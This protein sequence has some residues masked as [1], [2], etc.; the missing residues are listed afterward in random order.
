[1][2]EICSECQNK[3]DL[4]CFCSNVN[5]CRTCL[6]EHKKKP[7]RHKVIL[8]NDPDIEMLK[9]KYSKTSNGKKKKGKKQKGPKPEDNAVLKEKTELK[10][11][12]LREIEKLIHFKDETLA[13]FKGETAKHIATL[14]RGHSAAKSYTG[15]TLLPRLTELRKAAKSLESGEINKKNSIVSK[16]A[17]GVHVENYR[18]FAY[19]ATV[20]EQCISIE[21]AFEFE[22]SFLPLRS[23]MRIQEYYEENISTMDAKLSELYIEVLEEKHAT[24]K[25]IKLHKVNLGNEGA[26]HLGTLLPCFANLRVLK[27]QE[28]QLNSDG[29]K[30]LAQGLSKC[31]QLQKL[32]IIRNSLTGP[33]MKFIADSIK[34]ITSIVE[35]D[36]TRNKL[37]LEGV[38]HLKTALVNLKELK[39]LR[40]TKNSLDDESAE[41]ISSSVAGLKKL[42]SFNLRDN[43]FE[44]DGKMIIHDIVPKAC[45]I[46]F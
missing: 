9:K 33:G 7:G 10:E 37:G 38:Q 39:T 5:I 27:L 23:T 1:M 30:P 21:N 31:V 16:A 13:K 20:Q 44:H 8:L 24:R 2:E 3:A 15:Q 43:G 19:T 42:M 18:L 25:I 26:R 17:D 14:Q 28:N 36:F 46:E 45:N 22:V 29:A 40:L 35:L 32:L 34:D 11:I 4:I 41:V 6:T 12:L